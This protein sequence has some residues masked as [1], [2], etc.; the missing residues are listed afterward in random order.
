[1]PSLFTDMMPHVSSSLHQV[2]HP[3]AYNAGMGPLGWVFMVLVFGL[4][5]ITYWLSELREMPHF[6][7]NGGG[8]STE[9]RAFVMSAFYPLLFLDLSCLFIMS[10]WL[11]RSH[12]LSYWGRLRIG[13][14]VALWIFFITC[15]CVVMGNN[16]ENILEGR[17]LHWHAG[18]T[19][20][21]A[22]LFD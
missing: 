18:D 6:W 19:V 1:M 4:L 22:T 5:C 9:F 3:T 8:Y 12:S 14:G 16:V 15:L 20:Q 13:C 21:T 17:D 11:S 2:S 7:A 10:F